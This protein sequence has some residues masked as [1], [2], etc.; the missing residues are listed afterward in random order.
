MKLKDQKHMF[1]YHTTIGA[2]LRRFISEVGFKLIEQGRKLLK[3]YPSHRCGK[4]GCIV[5]GFATIC[6]YGKVCPSCEKRYL[7]N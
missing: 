4:C 3:K 6:K 7:R 2:K 1:L 5:D